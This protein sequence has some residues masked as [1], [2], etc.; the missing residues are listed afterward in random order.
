MSIWQYFTFES[1][2]ECWYK[3]DM[4]W[5][6]IAF[7]TLKLTRANL[8][9]IKDALVK[10]VTANPELSAV[11]FLIFLIVTVALITKYVKSS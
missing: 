8:V 6:W 10:L 5:A 1:I 2:E 4:N 11:S 7:M 3:W 9:R